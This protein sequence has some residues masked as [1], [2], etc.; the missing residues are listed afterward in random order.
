MSPNELQCYCTEPWGEIIEWFGLEGTFEIT[1]STRPGCSKPHPSCLHQV[2]APLS[3]VRSDGCAQPSSFPMARRQEVVGRHGATS[4]SFCCGHWLFPAHVLHAGVGGQI[5]SLVWFFKKGIPP[6]AFS[7]NLSLCFWSPLLTGIPF[8]VNA[9][10][11]ARCLSAMKLFVF[12]TADETL[13][14]WYSDNFCYTNRAE[15]CCC[16]Y[17]A[18]SYK[19]NIFFLERKGKEESIQLKV[20]MRLST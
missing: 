13:Y 20:G 11:C 5:C 4:P 16:Q 18:H 2:V 15:E 12:K 3:E 14:V 9:L 7:L 17:E 19:E 10:Q 6:M 8:C 1:P